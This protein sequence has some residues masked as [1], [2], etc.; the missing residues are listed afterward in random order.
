MPRIPLYNQ[1]RGP[2]VQ[3]E[4]RGLGPKLSSKVF[5]RAAA[6]PGEVAA[7]ALGDIAK[8]AADFEVREQKAEL[9]AAERD[10]MNKADDAAFDFVINN[11]DDNHRAYGINSNQFKADW[12][13]SNVDSYEGLNSRQR[14]ALS[15]N[16]DRRMQLKLQ[17][18]QVN[19]FNRGQARKTEVF[20]KAAEGLVRD[21]AASQDSPEMVTKYEEELQGLYDSAIEQGL[22][23]N[24]T[25]D[26]VKFEVQREV[27]RGLTQDDSKS[28][29]FY[30]VLEDDI[31]DGKGA[32]AQNTLDEREQLAGMLSMH[33]N[34]LENVAVA[35][36]NAN[37]SDALAGMTIATNASTRASKLGDGLFAADELRRLGQFSAADKLEVDLRAKDAALSTAETLMFA[38]D[39][40]VK[41]FMAEQK[42]LLSYARP[43]EEAT[44]LAQYTAMQNVIAAR[45][46]AIQEDAAGYVYDSYFAKYNKA[47]SP[48]ELV[49][50]QTEMG[51]PEAAIRPFTKREFNTF[52]A[53]MAE[54]DAMGQIDLMT[55]FFSRFEAGDEQMMAMRGATAL[56]LSRAQM[57]AMS[58]P[59]DPRAMDLLNS[60]GVDEALIKAS[61]K[62]KDIKA[63]DIH[64]A[65]DLQLEDYQKTI[66]GNVV[67]GY[68]DQTSTAGRLNDVF[69]IKRSMYRLAETY[70]LAGDDTETA[71]KKAAAFITEQYKFQEFDNS[72]VRLP[73]Q[74][75]KQKFDMQKVLQRKLKDRR[76]LET[77][78]MIPS[79]AGV[80]EAAID[81]TRLAI[82][83]GE[84]RSQ[85]RW[86]TTDD[87][88]GV[89]LLDQFGNPVKRTKN[90]FGESGEFNI[91]IS[92]E[93]LE[94]MAEELAVTELESGVLL[95]DAPRIVTDIDEQDDIGIVGITGQ[96][97]TQ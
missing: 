79:Q 28:L 39:A 63:A 50:F 9:E 48:S 35:E 8:V 87:D 37:G 24:F 30:E 85:G 97:G 2:A 52:K 62:D 68:L 43:G 44:A 33:I 83:A 19:A 29:T 66:V 1:G 36:A 40:T 17:P 74:Y 6:A 93:D 34:E 20:N 57:L 27:I 22:Q 53:Q 59:G 47:P 76:Y 84:V 71:A 61:L 11:T 77:D 69:G 92:F 96:R 64:S 56:G 55:Q 13:Q 90:E 12:L 81:E 89:I 70:V 72:L 42:E 60:A 45:A 54:A 5:E 38:D 41:E 51:V 67:S 21:I 91:Y 10:L 4:T 58:R 25:P 32:Y 7:K 3:M 73:A 14:A 82:Y 95:P 31:L 46:A 15:N 88:K 94:V 23:I 26:G 75:D 78:L 16:I 86:H 65:V 80:A 49:K 18:G